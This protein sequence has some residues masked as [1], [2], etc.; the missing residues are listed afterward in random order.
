[1]NLVFAAFGNREHFPNAI[2][3]AKERSGCNVHVISNI[4]SI[5]EGSVLCS[6]SM[7]HCKSDKLINTWYLT[8]IKWF[9]LLWYCKKYNVEF[10]VYAPDWDTLVMHN[11]DGL[12]SSIK[13]YDIMHVFEPE[14]HVTSAAVVIRSLDILEEYCSFV[15]NWG[16]EPF[17]YED[18]SDMS[19]WRVLIRTRPLK[20]VNLGEER[21]GGVFDSN[22]FLGKDVYEH[23]GVGKKVFFI[24]GKPHFKRLSD[25]KLLKA[26][27]LHCWGVYKNRTGEL[28]SKAGLRA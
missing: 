12:L 10:P 16:D 14:Q 4:P 7:L 24:D 2:K 1:M 21:D 27:C 6:P 22:I 18:Y 28:M 20:I 5:S 9:I 17:E 25:G 11:V 3:A 15:D 26:Y 8:H 23:D 19:A 13:D